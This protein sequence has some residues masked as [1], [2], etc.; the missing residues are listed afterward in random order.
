MSQHVISSQCIQNGIIVIYGTWQFCHVVHW[1]VT[2]LGKK[3]VFGQK[4]ATITR[5]TASVQLSHNNVPKSE[6]GESF[7][8]N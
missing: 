8:C 4:N 5:S 6:N 1:W 7:R 2:V 3:V